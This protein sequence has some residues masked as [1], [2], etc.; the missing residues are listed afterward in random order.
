MRSLKASL[1][2]SCGRRERRQLK[3]VKE[4]VGVGAGVRRNGL[5][6]L[7]AER[8]WGRPVTLAQA[9]TCDWKRAEAEKEQR[10][11]LPRADGEDGDDEAGVYHPDAAF[12][13]AILGLHILVP[14]HRRL[15]G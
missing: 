5:I 1:E 14:S 13:V 12:G 8:E 10:S 15:T 4:L 3:A 2:R 9:M 11:A 7:W 6:R